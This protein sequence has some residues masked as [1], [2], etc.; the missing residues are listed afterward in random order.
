MTYRTQKILT[1]FRH[2]SL[3]A[4]KMASWV[5][6]TTKN[7]IW[8]WWNCTRVSDC[9]DG[10]LPGGS[11]KNLLFCFSHPSVFHTQICIIKQSQTQLTILQPRKIA[12]YSEDRSTI[13]S[14][15]LS[16][17]S[18][19]NKN[20]QYMRES[21]TSNSFCMTF[22]FTFNL[23]KNFTLTPI[24]NYVAQTLLIENV[25]CINHFHFLVT[26][27]DLFVSVSCLVSVFHRSIRNCL[28][29]YNG[30]TSSTRTLYIWM[31]ESSMPI[32]IIL[33]SWGWKARNVAAGGEAMKVV[34][35]CTYTSI[36]QG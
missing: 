10:V 3:V 14:Y 33:L 2:S 29:I 20:I 30:V 24:S 36:Q 19:W 32:A 11:C 28:H 21:K 6:C 8:S 34:I 35:V 1:C 12:L 31:E 17:R 27:I 15:Y 9:A 4:S 22:E 16:I 26:I 7:C 13:K 23:Q 25:M 5:S 18:R